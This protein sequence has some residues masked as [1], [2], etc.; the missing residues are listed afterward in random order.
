MHTIMTIIMHGVDNSNMLRHR[1][2]LAQQ[3]VKF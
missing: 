1:L 2:S 3:S